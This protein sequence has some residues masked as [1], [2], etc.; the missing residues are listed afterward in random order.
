MVKVLECPERRFDVRDLHLSD[1]PIARHDAL[2]TGLCQNLGLAANWG[3]LAPTH[4]Q[5][6][7]RRAAYETCLRLAW[8]RVENEIRGDR[9]DQGMRK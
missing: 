7:N 1:D 6:V 4:V 3:F 5:S 9:V 8:L 2:G